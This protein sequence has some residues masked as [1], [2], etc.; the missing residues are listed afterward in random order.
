MWRTSNGER[1][2]KGSEAKVFA[3]TVL[4]ILTDL[5]LLPDEEL[6]IGSEVFDNLTRGQQI[7]TLA[8]VVH[9]LLD[10]NVPAVPLTALNESCIA[11]IYSTLLSYIQTEMEFCENA[12]LRQII[13]VAYT[14]STNSHI[15]AESNDIQEWK[16][17][18]DCLR[19]LILWDTDYDS[20]NEL[21]DLNP[22]ATENVKETLNISDEYY[23]SVGY[24]IAPD[25]EVEAIR[26]MKVICQR[27][28]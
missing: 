5:T 28:S 21:L 22:E 2:L 26:Q 10:E 23:T 7:W 13:S 6:Y 19:D 24:D 4:C 9:G 1:V 16:I 14:E 15:E 12:N 11:G 20:A 3:D 27:H 25:K 8:Q 18:V 17:V